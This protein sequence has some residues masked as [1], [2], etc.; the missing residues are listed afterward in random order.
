MN[1]KRLEEWE[2]AF[3]LLTYPTEPYKNISKYL[4]RRDESVGWFLNSK[5]IRKHKLISIKDK[6]SKLQIVE[7]SN[8]N[9]NREKVW[10][11]R[12]DCGKI[13]FVS[14]GHLKSGNTKSCGCLVSELKNPYMIVPQ[15]YFIQIK[16]GAKKRN[17]EFKIS[18]QYIIDLL[19]KQNFKCKLSNLEIKFVHTSNQESKKLTTASLDRIDSTKGYIEGNVQWIHKDF[20]PMKTNIREDK[21]KI[22]CR[23]VSECETERMQKEWRLQ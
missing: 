3:I 17:Y 5:K 22:M 10:K 6:F 19:I 18:I 15:W 13:T 1:K 8:I 7:F 20:Q 2:K 12:C 16:H 11:C 14:T 21:F 9:N 23:Q 4:G